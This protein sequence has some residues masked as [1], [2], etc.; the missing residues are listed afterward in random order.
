MDKDKKEMMLYKMRG[1]RNILFRAFAIN[2]VAVLIVWL[3][4]LTGFYTKLASRVM[5]FPP[6]ILHIYMMDMFGFWK[7]AGALL[8]LIPAIA[9]S[10][11]I[12]ARKNK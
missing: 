9:L 2:Y 6:D 8:F 4:S 5:G 11:E 12:G 10:W 3:I 1:W 7:I